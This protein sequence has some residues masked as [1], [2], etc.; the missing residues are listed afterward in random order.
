MGNN[1][2]PSIYKKKSK[3]EQE[4]QCIDG[5]LLLIPN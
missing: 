2:G 4:Q 5:G 1:V 3:T